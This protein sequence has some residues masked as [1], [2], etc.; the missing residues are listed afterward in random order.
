M[1]T[2]L[3]VLALT[4][5]AFALGAS[6]LVL[7]E[8]FNQHKQ[9]VILNKRFKLIDLKFSPIRLKDL[10]MTYNLCIKKEEYILASQILD[11]MKEEFPE[12]YKRFKEEIG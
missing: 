12:D 3:I 1:Q 2:F 6:M 4:L 11:T 7:H 9:L 10:I 5:S 8:L